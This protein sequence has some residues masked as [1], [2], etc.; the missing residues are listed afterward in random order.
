MKFAIKHPDLGKALAET[1]KDIERAVTSGMRDATAG[2]KQDLREDVVAAGFGERLSR[3]WRGKTF[4]EV[5]ESAEAAAYVWSRAPKIV[6]AFD[7]GV[8]IRSVR[9][10][11]LAIPTAAAGKSGRSAAGSREKITPEGWQRRTGL[12][13]RFVYRRGRPSLLVADDARINTRGLAARNRRKTGQVSVIVFILVPQVALK[14]RLDV[15][16]AAKR[17]AARVPSLIAR[18]WPQS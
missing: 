17:Q 13:L 9:G 11:F 16:G 4:P 1:E 3:T 7:R 5:G 10:P 8:V 12:K 2:L 15:E 6:D 18:H 14:K